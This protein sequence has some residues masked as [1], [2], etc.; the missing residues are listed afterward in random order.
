MKDKKTFYKLM[1]EYQKAKGLKK[2][3][4][5]QKEAHKLYMRKWRAKRNVEKSN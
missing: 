2:R 3:N 5:K 1:Y 4:K